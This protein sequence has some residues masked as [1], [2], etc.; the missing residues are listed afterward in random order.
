[1]LTD[2][3]YQEWRANPATEAYFRFLKD[4]RQFLLSE[5]RHQFESATLDAW[6]A[7]KAHRQAILQ[8]DFSA[9]ARIL[10]DL[11]EQRAADIQAFYAKPQEQK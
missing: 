8:T 9:M 6:N 3:E 10:Q 11:I 1:M 4:F 5:A 2:E 7:D